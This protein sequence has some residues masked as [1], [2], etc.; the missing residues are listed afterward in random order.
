MIVVE[1]VTQMAQLH[2]AEAHVARPE[3]MQKV[4]HEAASS[5]RQTDSGALTLLPTSCRRPVN[6]HTK[7]VVSPPP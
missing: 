1:F 3:P 5:L 6:V 4:L 7:R 2:A